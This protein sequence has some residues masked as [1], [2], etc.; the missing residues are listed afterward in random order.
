MS[1]TFELL[2]G[3]YRAVNRATH[4]TALGRVLPAAAVGYAVAQLGGQL[5]GP[6]IAH[7]TGAG[8]P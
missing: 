1:V 5:F 7:P 2:K 4:R 3:G 6:E 8:R